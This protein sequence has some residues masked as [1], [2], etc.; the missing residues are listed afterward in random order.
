MGN[1]LLNTCNTLCFALVILS[2]ASFLITWAIFCG[3]HRETNKKLK[4]KIVIICVTSFIIMICSM[5]F[6]QFHPGGMWNEQTSERTCSQCEERIELDD[7]F[8]SECGASVKE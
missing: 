8:C 4:K 6:L 1:I 2:A 7:K 5:A 3:Y